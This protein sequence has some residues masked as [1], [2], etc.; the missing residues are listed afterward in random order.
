MLIYKSC[1]SHRITTL[2]LVLSLILGLS[3]P[4][5][6]AGS[7]SPALPA[8]YTAVRVSN[9][10]IRTYGHHFFHNGL[11]AVFEGEDSGW[12]YMDT[13]GKIV[14]T[15][16]NGP[17][18][19]Y[20]FDF[21]EGLAPFL[22][23]NGKMGYMDTT[24]K[25]V[26]P[27][28]FEYYESM[29]TVYA[30]RFINGNALVFNVT[31]H[32][33]FGTEGTWTQI[34]KTGKAVPKTLDENN[35]NVIYS[36]AVGNTSGIA[37]ETIKLSGVSAELEFSEG[38]ALLNW[39]GTYYIISKTGSSSVV[40]AVSVKAEPAQSRILYNGQ[41]VSLNA[42]VINGNNYFKL[43]DFAAIMLNNGKQFDVTWNAEKKAIELTTGKTYTVVGGELQ[44][45]RGVTETAVPSNSAIYKDGQLI[46]LT[47]YTIGGNNFF[48]LRDLCK[49]FDIFAGWDGTSK[50]VTI[51]TTKPY[52]E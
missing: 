27:A 36:D 21:S 38:H 35:E 42:Y 14:L 47:A 13:N 20:G 8:G 34:D 48:K 32:N 46:S 52:S 50:T 37:T 3:V 6:A 43:R 19:P 1:L 25:V 29:G 16:S 28:R 26:I 44:P 41:A 23:H 39:N 15:Q 7:D 18:Y 49:T 30:G 11:I 31:G 4:V 9:N 24:G 51:D 10:T 22:D 5:M 45:G 12:A 33:S 17:A 2:I 40:P